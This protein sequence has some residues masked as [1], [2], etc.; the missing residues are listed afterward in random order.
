M[1]N[2]AICEPTGG[3]GSILFA[4][5]DG[6]IASAFPHH[7]A[8]HRYECISYTGIVHLTGEHTDPRQDYWW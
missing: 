8:L 3:V 6:S 4:H 5:R 7:L 2:Q 1:P